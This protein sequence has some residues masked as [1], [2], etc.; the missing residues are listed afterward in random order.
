MIISASRRTD[1]PAFFSEWFINRIEAQYACVRN[2]MN[3]RQISKINLAPD[4]V[5]CIVFWSKNPKPI[6][7]KLDALNDYMYYFQFTLNA[8]DRDYETNLPSLDERIQTFQTLSELIGRQRVI[9]RYDPIILNDRYSVSW[10]SAKFEYIANQLCNYTE[11]V[12]VSFIDL[13]TKISSCAREKNICELSY[14]QKNTVAK[15]LSEI[16]HSHHLK[17]DTC[18]EAIDLSA[19]DIDHAHCIDDK[20]IAGLLGCS[21]DVSK[22]KNQRLECGCAVSIDLGLYNTCQNGCVYCYANHSADVRKR[23]LEAYDPNSPLLCS[24]ITEAD[25]ITERKVKRLRN[26]QLSFLGPD[27]KVC[28]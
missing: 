13:Y 2:P 23:N 11:K 8:Y 14:A 16:A 5:D 26:M 22:D 4:I 7:G 21:I 27:C 10:H 15:N 17:I 12:T 20:L 1:I 28:L 19:Y 24:Q 9:W 25:K 6:I 18:A 3:I